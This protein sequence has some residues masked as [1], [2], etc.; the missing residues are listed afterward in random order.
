MKGCAFLGNCCEN[1]MGTE[2]R[3]KD[4]WD[5]QNSRVSCARCYHH[6]AMK[7]STRRY[8]PAILAGN[9]LIF[10]SLIPAQQSESVVLTR[11]YTGPDGQTHAE[12]TEVRFVPRVD[13]IGLSPLVKANGFFYLKLPAGHVQEWH[14]A[15]R[16]QYV[17]AL[18]GRNEIE[19]V[20]GEKIPNGTGR[21]D[22]SRRPYRKRPPVSLRRAEGL[23]RGR[24]PVG[25]VKK[26]SA[27]RRPWAYLKTYPLRD[28]PH[29]KAASPRL[30][31][32]VSF[33]YPC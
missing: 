17:I 21:R 15:P 12:R 30:R 26:W 13:G 7:L 32:L 11:L 6:A 4:P 14:P 22:I 16:R 18:S 3:T 20:N 1:E 10:A 27:T 33:C 8:V 23:Y 31:G 29:S 2:S 25:G 9:L 19:L 24:S 5:C 28:M